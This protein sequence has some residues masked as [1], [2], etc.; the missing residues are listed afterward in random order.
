MR[1]RSQET[2]TGWV[3]A[4]PD[5]DLDRRLEAEE[6]PFDPTR[7]QVRS[8]LGPIDPDA[9]GRAARSRGTIA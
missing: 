3:G 6:V 4:G 9:R 8:L 1:T 2:D 7:P 5:D